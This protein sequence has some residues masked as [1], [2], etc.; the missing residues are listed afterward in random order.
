MNNKNRFELMKQKGL[1]HRMRMHWVFSYTLWLLDITL[2]CLR[3]D[4][5]FEHTPRIMPLS[6]RLSLHLHK[7]TVIW[8]ISAVHHIAK[9]KC[10][11]HQHQQ[12]KTKPECKVHRC[13]SYRN[14]ST[15][16]VLHFRVICEVCVT[17]NI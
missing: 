7:A 6:L 14:R 2:R 12:Q 5:L 10:Q 1:K 13:M 8:L 11:Q 16:K 15:L 4:E 3:F 17:S 9:R